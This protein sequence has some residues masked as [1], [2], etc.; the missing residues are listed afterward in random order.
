MSELFISV[1]IISH[2]S[3]GI[4]QCIT[5]LKRQLNNNDEIIIVDDHSEIVFQKNLQAHCKMKL[6]Q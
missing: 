3:E 2:N 1:V 4:F 6:K 5:A